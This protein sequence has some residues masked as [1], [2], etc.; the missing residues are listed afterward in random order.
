MRQCDQCSLLILLF[1]MFCPNFTM[2]TVVLF[3]GHN[4]AYVRI[5]KQVWNNKRERLLSV[6]LG[7]FWSLIKWK[8]NLFRHHANSSVRNKSKQEIMFFRI[9]SFIFKMNSVCYRFHLL[10]SK[11]IDFCST[12]HFLSILKPNSIALGSHLLLVTTTRSLGIQSSM[13]IGLQRTTMGGDKK[14]KLWPNVFR[15]GSNARLILVRSLNKNRLR[16]TCYQY[17]LILLRITQP[18]S[19]KQTFNFSFV[20][21]PNSKWYHQKHTNINLYFR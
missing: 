6:Y 5:R 4:R 9:V 8:C 16:W 13:W 7:C 14:E 15:F 1:A 12:F 20:W 19:F 10:I 3:H 2:T 21:S 18:W 11:F 17:C